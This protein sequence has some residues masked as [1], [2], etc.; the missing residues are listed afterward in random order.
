MEEARA[1]EGALIRLGASISIVS[2]PTGQADACILTEALAD[3]AISDRHFQVLDLCR[4]HA[5]TPMIV[6]DRADAS[7]VRALGG[8]GGLVRTL[9]LERPDAQIRTLSLGRYANAAEAAKRMAAGLGVDAAD[10]MLEPDGIY[11]QTLGGPLNPPD[12]VNHTGADGV[13]LVTGGARGVTSDCAVEVA[14]RTQGHFILMGRSAQTAWPA[15]LEPVPDLKS[16]RATLARNSG[17][18]DVP[19]RPADIDRLARQLLA[20]R[21]IDETLAR[22]RDTGT[23]AAYVPV[24]L[25]DSARI[26]SALEPALGGQTVSGLIHGAGV[27]ADAHVDKQTEESF[28]TVFGPKVDGLVALLDCLDMSALR[29]V[30]LFSSAS[31]VFGNPGQAN[32]AAANAWLNHAAGVIRK[33]SETIKVRSFCW[34]PWE[35]GM[36]DEGLAKMFAARGIPL[37]ARAEGARILADQILDAEHDHLLLT[38]G[39]EWGA[40]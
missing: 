40:E 39:E 21:E 20:S 14:R 17:R 11:V 29:H 38:V 34:G 24:D 4:A 22:I 2:A 3:G 36:V 10:V 19:K 6:L 33:A 8:C 26:K 15:W 12:T 28:G 32:Y 9:R 5:A 7:G 27:L 16:L 30:A 23:T 13:W 18:D 35:G 31:A 37:I 25:S 1:I